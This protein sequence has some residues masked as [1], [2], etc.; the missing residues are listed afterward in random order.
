MRTG[1]GVYCSLGCTLKNG[2]PARH[3]A[4]G[5]RCRH[6]HL[7]PSTSVDQQSNES[8]ENDNQNQE[9]Q[10]E[11]SVNSSSDQQFGDEHSRSNSEVGDIQT[12]VAPIVESPLHPQDQ[13]LVTLFPWLKVE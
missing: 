5:S 8:V 13:S 6:K 2:K 10:V 12:S 1:E 4:Y 7:V 3:Q 9:I 11:S